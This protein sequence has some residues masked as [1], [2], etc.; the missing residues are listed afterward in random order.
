MNHVPMA[1]ADMQR[2]RHD[3]RTDSGLGVGRQLRGR[4]KCMMSGHDSHD[5]MFDRRQCHGIFLLS[6]HGFWP[7]GLVRFQVSVHSIYSRAALP[8]TGLQ[9]PHPEY[10]KYHN[11]TV[12]NASI[13]GKQLGNDVV[14][15]AVFR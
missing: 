10:G 8:G 2:Q 14:V 3:G 1:N 7:T 5:H 9:S 11:F 15:V 12:L 13:I 4:Q 6:Q